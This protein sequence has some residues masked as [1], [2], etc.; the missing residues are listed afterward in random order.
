MLCE[1][2]TSDKLCL[3]LKDLLKIHSNKSIIYIS[4]IRNALNIVMDILES[5]SQSQL[6][7]ATQSSTNTNTNSIS[8]K[9]YYDIDI[10]GGINLDF[11][12]IQDVDCLIVSNFLGHIV[13]IEKYEVWT[14]HFFKYL[15]FDNRFTPYT[16]YN[17][18]NSCN[19]GNVSIIN[20]P[21]HN[22]GFIVVDKNIVINDDLS[23]YPYTFTNDIDYEHEYGC[24]F[25]YKIILDT[26]NYIEYSYFWEQIQIYNIPI[27]KFPCFS[28]NT[29]NNYV[30]Y[31]VFFSDISDILYESFINKNISVEKYY[32]P[33]E[34]TNN[35]DTFFYN[36]ILCLPCMGINKTIIDFYIDILKEHVYTLQ[37]NVSLI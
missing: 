3:S 2:N 35:I 32:K 22:D 8:S 16:F 4:D 36:N 20:F 25:L 15:I 19:Y 5:H 13:D 30:T 17:N 23:L 28:D 10:D 31:I 34:L 24:I 6:K 33:V 27:T 26:N 29:C 21:T 12:S 14:N 18:I 9:L 7:Y 37:Y 1:T 11:I